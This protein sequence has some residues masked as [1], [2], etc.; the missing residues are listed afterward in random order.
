M[1]RKKTERPP[2]SPRLRKILWLAVGIAPVV[3]YPALAFIISSTGYEGQTDHSIDSI[4]GA[5]IAL[6]I[7]VLFFNQGLMRRTHAQTNDRAYIF[8]LALAEAISIE[9]FVL[10]LLVGWNWGFW[11]MMAMGLASAWSLRPQT[12]QA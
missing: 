2:L 12:A 7:I 9:G 6:G 1:E 5:F 11:V 10:Y 3:I 4:I 8:C